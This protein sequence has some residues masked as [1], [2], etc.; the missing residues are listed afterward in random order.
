LS[1]TTDSGSLKSA[2]LSQNFVSTGSACAKAKKNIKTILSRY[3]KNAIF[4]ILFLQTKINKIYYFSDV[5]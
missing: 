3:L 4:F 2:L 5:A 1:K